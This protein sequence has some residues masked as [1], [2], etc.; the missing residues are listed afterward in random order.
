MS[1]GVQ[2]SLYSYMQ[3]STNESLPIGNLDQIAYFAN[4]SNTVR[5]VQTFPL[6]LQTSG[7]VSAI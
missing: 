2:M 7:T 1:N 5:V 3:M 6:L 4:H